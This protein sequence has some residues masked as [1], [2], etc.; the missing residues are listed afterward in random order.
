MSMTGPS[1]DAAAG[2]SLLELLIV[3]A[4][5]G[6]IAGLVSV[7]LLA[8]TRAAQQRDAVDGIRLALADARVQAM[9]R[10]GRETVQVMYEPEGRRLDVV[11]M[12][13]SRTWTN[14]PVEP[15]DDRGRGMDDFEAVFDGEGRTRARAWRFKAGEGGDTIFAIEFDPISGVPRSRRMTEEDE[16]RGP[17]FPEFPAV[18]GVG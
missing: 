9:R 2:F 3:V 11:W 16:R 8:S 13:Q 14:A 15:V 1:R 4:M 10:G 6:L 12:D 18:P 5:M 7:R 17:A